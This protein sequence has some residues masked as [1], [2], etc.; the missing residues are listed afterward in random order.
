MLGHLAHH[1]HHWRRVDD[2]VGYGRD[3]VCCA[4][5]RSHKAHPYLARNARVAFGGVTRALLVPHQNVVDPILIIV[6]G[7]VHGHDRPTG[8]PKNGIHA[9]RQ[10]SPNERMRAIECCSNFRS[11]LWCIQNFGV[12]LFHFFQF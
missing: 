11:C 12:V 2:G 9:L 6:N 10:Q 8:V 5:P 4:R 7:V 3:E 1:A